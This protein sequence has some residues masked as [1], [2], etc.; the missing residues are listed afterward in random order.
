[1]LSDSLIAWLFTLIVEVP[2]VA[3]FYCKQ[4]RRMAAIAACA[5]TVTNLAMN[6]LL[7]QLAGSEFRFLLIGE[8]AALTVEA[9]VYYI[10]A[11]ERGVGHAI[12]ASAVANTVSFGLG[13]V[14]APWLFQK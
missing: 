7:P 14:A 10:A 4:W 9:L 6:L 1:M 8:S 5:T 12:L 13:L 3:G 2:I 11:K